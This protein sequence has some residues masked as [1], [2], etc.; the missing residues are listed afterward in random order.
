MVAFQTFAEAYLIPAQLVLA[1]IGMGATLRV[2]DFAL[3]FRYPKGLLLGLGLQLMFVPGLAW[4]Y[5]TALG[6]TEGWSVGLLLVA[7]VPGGAMSNLLTHLGR[8]SVPLSIAVTT[9]TTFLCLGTVP[10]ILGLL[11]QEHL[12]PDFV[13]PYARIVRDIVFFL[14]IPLMVGM[15][16]LR[17][18]T[19]VAR[20]ISDWSIRGSVALI[21]VLVVSSLGSGRIRVAAHGWGAPLSILGFG[22]ILA[23]ATPHVCRLFGRYDDDTLALSVEIVV[24]NIGIAL[25]LFHF[26]FP[27]QPQQTEVLYT[28][29]F[30]SGLAPFLGVPMVVSHRLGKGVASLRKPYPRPAK[31]AT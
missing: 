1:M 24:R 30:F 14:L 8:G 2:T 25:L 7:A 20:P 28:A 23:I 15:V 27:G 4:V 26:F 17:V 12:P 10:L 6:L 9:V 18:W 19:R 22:I 29:L 16:I 5:I 3:V 13:F 21:A 31:E 11:A